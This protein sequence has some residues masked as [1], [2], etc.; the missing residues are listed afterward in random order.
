[1]NLQKE[2]IKMTSNLNSKLTRMANHKEEL[3]KKY[4]HMKK[5]TK[6]E[7]S[8]ANSQLA[9]MVNASQDAITVS[10]KCMEGPYLGRYLPS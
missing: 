3:T 8:K 6:L 9:V 10:G 7:K 4:W 1:M 5:E 2:W